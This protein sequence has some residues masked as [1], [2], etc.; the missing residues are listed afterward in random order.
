VPEQG[1]GDGAGAMVAEWSNSAMSG[2][3]KVAPT[4][5]RGQ[6]STTR[7]AVPA[8]PSPPTDAAAMLPMGYDTVRTSRL[9]SPA[10]RSVSP[11]DATSGSVKITRGTAQWSA[12]AS[13]VGPRMAPG[14][15]GPGTYPCG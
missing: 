11:T 2:P 4:T 13:T 10:A 15:S 7:W 5:T 14:R 3:V 8:M 6:S 12:H 9:W 1:E